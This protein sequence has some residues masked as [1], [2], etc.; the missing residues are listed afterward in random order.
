[1]AFD[2]DVAAEVESWRRERG[3]GVSE[4]VNELIRRGMVASPPSKPFVQH[5]SAT[6]ARLDVTNIGEVIEVVEGS[7]D[8]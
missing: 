8:R 5:A 4:A 7:R 1:M 6:G 2:P 3:I